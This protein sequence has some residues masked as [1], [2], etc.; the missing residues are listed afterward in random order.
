MTTETTH[1]SGTKSGKTHLGKEETLA[2]FNCQLFGLECF[3]GVGY[4]K[5]KNE[6]GD[7]SFF[8]RIILAGKITV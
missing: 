1:I 8:F 6:Y 2:F 5:K 7:L 4:V 3:I